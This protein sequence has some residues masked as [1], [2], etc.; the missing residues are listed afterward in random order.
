MSTKIFAV[1]LVSVFCLN[2]GMYEKSKDYV[3]ESEVLSVN[4]IKES[5][6][7]KSLA[8]SRND[9]KESKR[10]YQECIDNNSNN[11]AA[12]ESYKADYDRNTEEYIKIQQQQ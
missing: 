11:E 10:K 5:S 12:C 9:V 6:K 8:D 4:P 3:N 7:N 1:L 2:C